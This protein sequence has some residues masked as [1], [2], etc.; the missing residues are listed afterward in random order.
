MLAGAPLLGLL[1]ASAMLQA[2][3]D[4]S[5]RG[6]RGGRGAPGVAAR[7]PAGRP[8]RGL[9]RRRAHAASTAPTRR[10]RRVD[11]D[12]RERSPARSPGC[13]TRRAP[14]CSSSSASTSAGAPVAGAV[15]GGRRA[16][17]GGHAL[18]RHPLAR[19]RDA[20][21]RRRPAPGRHRG[22]LGRAWYLAQALLA[23][24][25]L[26]TVEAA[27]EMAVQYAKERF[28]FGRAIGSYQ[29]IKHGLTEVLRRQENARSLLYYAG[30]AF[31][32]QPERVRP[33]RQRGAL[34]RRR[35]ARLRGA[36]EH[37]HPRRH[38]RD[39]GARR[40]ALLP[41]RPAVPAAARRSAA[42]RPT[43]WPS[44]LLAAA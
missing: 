44:E 2:A 25:S 8:R 22:A 15:D 38:R 1:P 23:A 3:G 21:R 18:R 16:G 33:R 41:P 13:P 9:D 34:G 39:V 37:R 43:A 10:A 6:R 28:T 5:L 27:L 30:W 31:D 35:G 29:A 14:T 26:G 24:E 42:T 7:A 11:G 40:A 32:D 36:P 19:P 4:E 17:R 20:R 12:A